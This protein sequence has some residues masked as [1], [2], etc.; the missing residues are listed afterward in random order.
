MSATLVIK[1]AKVVTVDSEFSIREAIAVNDDT[2]V[3]VGSNRD[4]EAMIGP[5]TRVMD[6]GG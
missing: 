4:V 5:E 2:I 3:A 1:N 6:L